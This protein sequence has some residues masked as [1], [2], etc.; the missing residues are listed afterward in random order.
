MRLSHHWMY[1]KLQSRKSNAAVHK[2]AHIS[3]RHETKSDADL[4]RFT[5][6]RDDYLVVLAFGSATGHTAGGGQFY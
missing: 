6:Y 5:D 1:E 3:S 4:S 2:R